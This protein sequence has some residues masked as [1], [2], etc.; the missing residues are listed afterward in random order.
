MHT[1]TVTPS[2]HDGVQYNGVIFVE[3]IVGAWEEMDLLQ[4]RRYQKY[5]QNTDRESGTNTDR[6]NGTNTDSMY[7]AGSQ[8]C[9]YT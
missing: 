2:G 5:I 9:F 4:R 8:G 6:E 1:L 3:H 7:N